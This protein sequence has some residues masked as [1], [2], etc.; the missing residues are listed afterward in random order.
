VNT[1]IFYPPAQYISNI[2][3]AQQAVV[4]FTTNHMFTLGEIVSFRV[5]KPYGMIQMNN[6]S[7]R[8]ISLSADTITIEVDT[9]NFNVFIYPPSGLVVYPAMA[10][11][12]G[13]GVV[14][15]SFVAMTNLE[16]AFDNLPPGG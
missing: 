12:A 1:G 15:N 11:P 4:T 7:S 8:V 13:S 14:P 2:T 10:V 5:S 6:I 3:N 16:D 9:L